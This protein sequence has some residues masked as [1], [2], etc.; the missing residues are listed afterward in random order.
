MEVLVELEA[1]TGPVDVQLDADVEAEIEKV[2]TAAEKT[3]ASLAAVVGEP[4]AGVLGALV[5]ARPRPS[6][7]GLQVLRWALLQP[8]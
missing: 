7:Q 4:Y 8:R 5:T 1:R 3:E 6:R 2:R